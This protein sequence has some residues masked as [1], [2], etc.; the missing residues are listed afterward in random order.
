MTLLRAST[1]AEDGEIGDTVWR[2]DAERIA[3]SN[4]AR[5]AARQG[6][7]PTDHSALHARRIRGPECVPQPLWDELGIFRHKANV[8]VRPGASLRDTRFFPE[9]H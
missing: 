4:E 5:F 9:A 7:A 1:M 6:F 3:A 2:P 8:G